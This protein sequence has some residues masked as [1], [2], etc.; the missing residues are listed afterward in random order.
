MATLLE[1]IAFLRACIRLNVFPRFIKLKFAIENNSTKK[2]EERAKLD[3][4]KCEIK[5]KYSELAQCE[6]ELY[7]THLKITRVFSNGTQSFS[8][9]ECFYHM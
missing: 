2:V 7:S 6:L 9:D 3:W 5:L 8:L 4:L 1:Y